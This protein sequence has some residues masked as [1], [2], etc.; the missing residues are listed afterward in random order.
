MLSYTREGGWRG[1]AGG[2]GFASWFQWTRLA[3]CYCGDQFLKHRQ[4][5]QHMPSAVCRAAQHQTLPIHCSQQHVVAG[6][7]PWKTPQVVLLQSTSGETL[8][9]EQ[10]SSAH[11]RVNFWRIPKGE[12]PASSSG[13]CVCV[14]VC[15]CVHTQSLQS[16][17]TLWAAM[18]CSPPGSSVHG[19]LQTRILEWV[20]MPSS[21]ASSPP[22]D[23]TRIS[24]GSCIA[25]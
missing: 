21:R 11:P 22:R 19:I 17:P 8:S 10:L 15:V 12:F 6:S 25:G 14:C 23:Q 3:S 13:V 18:N 9:Y 2:K 16:C 24:C 5:P 4:L 20:A 7:C 1:T